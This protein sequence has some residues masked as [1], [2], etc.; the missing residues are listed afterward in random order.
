MDDLCA[1]GDL[2]GSR[3][4]L[5]NFDLPTKPTTTAGTSRFSQFPLFP[6]SASPLLLCPIAPCPSGTETEPEADAGS[7]HVNYGVAKIEVGYPDGT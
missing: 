2:G 6:Q 1:L 7:I 5:F 3:V 4:L